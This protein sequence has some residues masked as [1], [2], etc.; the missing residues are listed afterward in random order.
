M[1][2]SLLDCE[3]ISLRGRIFSALLLCFANNLTVGAAVCKL[4]LW[5]RGRS[6]TFYS[7]QPQVG[8]QKYIQTHIQ[9]L[10]NLTPEPLAIPYFLFSHPI[11]LWFVPGGEKLF[12][13]QVSPSRWHTENHRGKDQLLYW[14]HGT[15]PWPLR[16]PAMREWTVDSSGLEWGGG[17][18]GRLLLI[19]P[20]GGGGG[21]R[22]VAASAESRLHDWELSS[23]G[24]GLKCRH[25]IN[26]CQFK[27]EDYFNLGASL[28]R[29]QYMSIT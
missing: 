2:S 18:S 19:L 20:R 6:S 23:W 7:L 17:V 3:Q 24:P 22:G 10:P 28:Y 29:S 16:I 21:G 26:Q 13:A 11:P 9:N 14:D 8:M 25:Y 4:F 12:Y 15:I 1:K 5:W 27:R